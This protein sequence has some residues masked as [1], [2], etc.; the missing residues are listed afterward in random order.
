MF[1]TLIF[2]A[3]LWWA[4]MTYAFFSTMGRLLKKVFK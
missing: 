1:K 3:F 4:L 2:M